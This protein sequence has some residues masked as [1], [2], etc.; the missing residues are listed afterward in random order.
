MTTPIPMDSQLALGESE[1]SWLIIT[2]ITVSIRYYS[3]FVCVRVSLE[4][5]N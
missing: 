1:L 4:E 2:C 5:V 3:M